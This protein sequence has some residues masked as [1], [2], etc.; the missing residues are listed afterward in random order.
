MSSSNSNP[1]PPNAK[2]ELTSKVKEQQRQSALQKEAH[3]KEQASFPLYIKKN[4]LE[5]LKAVIKDMLETFAN[6]S[7][8]AK[9]KTAAGVGNSA[10]IEKL[11][12]EVKAAHDDTN[13]IIAAVSQ[14]YETWASRNK[15]HT[16]E[17]LS[18]QKHLHDHH[19]ARMY[20]VI[21]MHV[22]HKGLTTPAKGTACEKIKFNA[23]FGVSETGEYQYPFIAILEKLKTPKR[24]NSSM[25]TLTAIQSLALMNEAKQSLSDSPTRTAE[26]SPRFFEAQEPSYMTPQYNEFTKRL[27]SL[28]VNLYGKADTHLYETLLG[29]KKTLDQQINTG[30]FR[31]QDP[32]KALSIIINI[33]I[34]NPLNT[35]KLGSHSKLLKDLRNIKKEVNE[36]TFE[37]EPAITRS[38]HASHR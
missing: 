25:H 24:N 14:H 8:T 7:L 12:Q 3:L 13:K 18:D 6:T 34:I 38:R 21:L 16:F 26:S 11:E 22:Y 32:I 35:L 4:N 10:E 15:E 2:A 28:D 30:Q 17:L 9:A 33:F 5:I 29:H 23:A 1:T 20:A 31:G 19:A 36:M 27:M 37:E